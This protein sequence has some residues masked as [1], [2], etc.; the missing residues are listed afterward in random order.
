L[1]SAIASEAPRSPRRRTSAE[2][3]GRLVHDLR[4]SA[5]RTLVRSGVPE[6]T[7]MALLGHKTRSIFDR[8]NIVN[9]ADLREGVLKLAAFRPLDS[10]E[11]RRVVAIAPNPRTS[12]E[13]ARIGD[14]SGDT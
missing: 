10:S 5:A 3:P 4:R 13:E 9:E 12:T 2:V 14:P 11:S 6:R 8:Y 7:A 1:G